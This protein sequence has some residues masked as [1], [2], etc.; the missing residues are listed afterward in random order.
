MKRILGM[1][2]GQMVFQVPNQM[3]VKKKAKPY[4]AMIPFFTHP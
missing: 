1:I 3:T 4:A 2:F